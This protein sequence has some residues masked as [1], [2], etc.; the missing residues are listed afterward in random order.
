MAAIRSHLVLLLVALSIGVAY[1]SINS[2]YP[3]INASGL[4]KIFDSA[5]PYADLSGA[6]YSIKGNALLGETLSTQNAAV[7]IHH[8]PYCINYTKSDLKLS[9]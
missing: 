9:Y 1:S 3:T 4:K 6:F 5:K 7:I 8:Q 2:N